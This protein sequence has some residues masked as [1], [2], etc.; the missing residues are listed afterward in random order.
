MSTSHPIERLGSVQQALEHRLETV[1][2]QLAVL[3]QRSRPEEWDGGGDNTPFTE[4]VDASRVVDE[5]ESDRLAAARLAGD[6]ADLQGALERIRIG[7][8]GRCL[9]CGQAIAP[10]RLKALPEASFCFSCETRHEASPVGSTRGLD[11]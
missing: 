11:G 7:I 2:H 10:N 8:Y 4:R 6:I 3:T 5:R 1:I 9:D